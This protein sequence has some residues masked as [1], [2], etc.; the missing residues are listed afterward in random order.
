[1][2]SAV[3]HSFGSCFYAL[4]KNGNTVTA[5]MEIPRRLSFCHYRALVKP[6]TRF[7]APSGSPAA[8]HA[9]QP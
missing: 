7:S 3:H 9:P 8:S 6:A 4:T 5:Q 2:N 1:M